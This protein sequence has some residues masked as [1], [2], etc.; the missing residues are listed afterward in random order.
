MERKTVDKVKF[1]NICGKDFTVRI[2]KSDR[3][4]MSKCW[5]SPI[6]SKYMMYWNYKVISWKPMKTKIQFKNKLWKVL[7]YTKPQQWIIRTIWKLIH[8]R[9]K[10]EMWECKKCCGR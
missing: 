3:R 2:R 7:A 6:P 1:C 4:I 5:Y 9:K 8:G 10:W